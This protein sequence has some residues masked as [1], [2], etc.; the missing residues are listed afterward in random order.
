MCCCLRRHRSGRVHP[1]PTPATAEAQPAPAEACD[2]PD[3]LPALVMSASAV[4][5]R[6]AP[7]HWC[8]STAQ[9]RVVMLGLEGA[10][11]TSVCA[12]LEHGAAPASVPA[13]WANGDGRQ[14]LGLAALP[15]VTLRILTLAGKLELRRGWAQALAGFV[16]GGAVHGLVLCLDA[17]QAAADPRDCWL[18][19][20]EWQRCAALLPRGTPVLLLACK[21]DAVATPVD[22][23]GLAAACGLGEWAGPAAAL[24]VSARGGGAGLEDGMRWL[25]QG[26]AAHG[27]AVL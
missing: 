2:A 20:S 11:L 17:V 19:A 6:V 5:P 25:L 3:A 27:I 24:G 9:P 26:R 14:A 1:E 23:A 18:L 8:G 22:A 4:G 13:T 15:G 16:R 21:A 10:G 12:A 7:G